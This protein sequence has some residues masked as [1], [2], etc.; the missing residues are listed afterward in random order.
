[1]WVD[2][3]WPEFAHISSE[4]IQYIVFQLKILTLILYFFKYESL[5]V[6]YSI[7]KYG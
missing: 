1:M 2:F 7:T 6:R 5:E 4:H 3:I